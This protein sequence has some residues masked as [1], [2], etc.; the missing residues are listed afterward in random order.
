MVAPNIDTVLSQIKHWNA[1]LKDAQKLGDS[2]SA[3]KAR[4]KLEKYKRL[5]RILIQTTPK[6][7]KREY[8]NIG[9]EIKQAKKKQREL[10]DKAFP[11]SKA[12]RKHKEL[13]KDIETNVRFVKTMHALYGPDKPME[14]EKLNKPS[15]HEYK[16]LDYAKPT[17][18][19][20]VY[21]Q[22]EQRKPGH[23]ARGLSKSY[24][25]VKKVVKVPLKLLRKEDVN[26]LPA[27]EE[28]RFSELKEKRFSKLEKQF[29]SE[30]RKRG[31]APTQKARE[32]SLT[33][34]VAI[35][36]EDM[37]VGAF[38]AGGIAA[39]NYLK[40]KKKKKKKR[41]SDEEEY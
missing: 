40:T 38:I 13:G 11:G 36:P 34:N 14:H 1:R 8:K 35:S 6:N 19:P 5:H 20:T 28:K 21:Q 22:P 2:K 31:G 18:I 30:Y 32:M 12:Y 27:L 3:I 33:K 25:R 37:K 10:A 4:R 29:K 23:I 16:P 24:G 17:E 7:L 26:E 9:T 41:N 39:A 15:D